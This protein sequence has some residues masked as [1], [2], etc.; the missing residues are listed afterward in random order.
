[1]PQCKCVNAQKIETV[2]ELLEVE[3]DVR[4]ELLAG[5]TESQVA[6]VARYANR[7]PNI[8][9]SHEVQNKNDIKPL[10]FLTVFPVFEGACIA[11][12]VAAGSWYKWLARQSVKMTLWRQ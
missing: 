2:F 1:M 7:Y 11:V 8:E 9:L 12:T 3:D 4:S 6:D 5:L 10:V